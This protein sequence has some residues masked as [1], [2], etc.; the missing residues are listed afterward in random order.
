[1]KEADVNV[2]KITDWF[3]N[4]FTQFAPTGIDIT[5]VDQLLGAIDGWASLHEMF[6]GISTNQETNFINYLAE[7]QLQLSGQQGVFVTN[8]NLTAADYRNQYSS[9]PYDE[10]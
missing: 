2:V 1:M 10:L 8:E 6:D 9:V 3:N 7:L 5:Y 4:R